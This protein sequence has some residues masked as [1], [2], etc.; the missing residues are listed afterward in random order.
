MDIKE[1]IKLVVT[2]HTNL[3]KLKIAIIKDDM[4]FKQMMNM[5]QSM[6]LAQ[7]KVSYMKASTIEPTQ[8]S[9]YTE[10]R[11][12]V[13]QLVRLTDR[14]GMRLAPK[15]QQ[16]KATKLMECCRYC[17]GH[18]PHRSPCK[19]RGAT[20]NN[21]GQKGHYARVC[22]I[23]K[24][25]KIRTSFD[26]TEVDNSE[27]HFPQ[28]EVTKTYPSKEAHL[29]VA[30]QGLVMEVDSAAEANILPHKIFRQQF[31]DLCDREFL[32]L[33]HTRKIYCI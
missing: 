25:N 6:E 17:D 27:K 9:T 19:A 7:R 15:K 4:T 28:R 2:L 22:E 20:C 1:A 8:E 12:D 32:Q 14:Q 10:E 30:Q 33:Y 13:N 3:P 23:K 24:V 5:A 11:L 29:Q 18:V 16:Q 26:L 21:C 31:C